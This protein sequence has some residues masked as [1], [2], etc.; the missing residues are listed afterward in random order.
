MGFYESKLNKDTKTRTREEVLKELDKIDK[1][2]KEK[3]DFVKTLK[4]FD[5]KDLENEFKR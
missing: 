1:K 3:S 5:S 2:D 4:E